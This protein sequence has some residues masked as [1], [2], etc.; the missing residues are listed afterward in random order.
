MS[1]PNLEKSCKINTVLTRDEFACRLQEALK[2]KTLEE[3]SL[4]VGVSIAA[5]HRWV[6]GTGFPEVKNLIKLFA[7]FDLSAA[8]LFGQSEQPN[9]RAGVGTVWV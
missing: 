3:I 1:I 9:Y 6:N 5:V 8:Y 2:G 7:E 4:P